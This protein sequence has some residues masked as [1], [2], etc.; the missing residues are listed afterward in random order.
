MRVIFEK[1]WSCRPTRK[2]MIDYP[3]GVPVLIPRAHLLQA[4]ERGIPYAV[5]A[6]GENRNSQA[7]SVGEV[8]SLTGRGTKRNRNRD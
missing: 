2:I 8:Q 7:E 1:A 6:D 3:A 5:V 4:D